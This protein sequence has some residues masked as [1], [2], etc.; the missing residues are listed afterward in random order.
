VATFRQTNFRNSDKG[1]AGVQNLILPLNSRKI[2]RRFRPDF[3]VSKE[4]F[5]TEQKFP[6]RV[7]IGKGDNFPLRSHV[8]T[9]V[10]QKVLLGGP[11]FSPFLLS[12]P[13]LSSFSLRLS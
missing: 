8:V 3:F 6:D 1:A 7:N 10:Y 11:T 12:P 13:G 5:P 2:G 4:Y 9:A